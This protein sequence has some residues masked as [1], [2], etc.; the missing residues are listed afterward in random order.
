MKTT[1]RARAAS[2]AR[3]YLL[4]GLIAAAL[5]A[6]QGCFPV[7]ATGVGAGAAMIADRRTSGAYV[8][9]EGIEW[10]IANRL[11]ERFG[12]AIHVNVTSYNRNVLL[13][14]EVPTDTIRSEIERSAAAADHVRGIVNETVVAG[15]SS[16]SARANDSL[17]T[18]NVK[19]RFVDSQRV[20]AHHVKVVTE[21]NVVF[22]MG[23]VTREEADAATEVARTSQGVKRVVRVFEYINQAEADRLDFKN[24]RSN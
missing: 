24:R 5:P 19:A 13:T 9:D 18:S 3:R 16:L 14:G 17:I 8:E 1:S 2:G 7:V 12:D 22:L 23:L 10:K 20:S 6:L 21:A 4:A 15:N 11:R